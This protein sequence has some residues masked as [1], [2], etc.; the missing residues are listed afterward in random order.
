[1]GNS[2]NVNQIQ[3]AVV[4]RF[5]AISL[6]TDD[7]GVIRIRSFSDGG[8]QLAARMAQR[9]SLTHHNHDDHV[10]PL[11]EHRYS[12]DVVNRPRYTRTSCTTIP[13]EDIVS[14][15]VFTVWKCGYVFK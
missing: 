14:I 5:K 10:P 11:E 9:N 7:N 4:D 6:T 8:A 2:M 15:K 12:F 3:T 13:E 1:M